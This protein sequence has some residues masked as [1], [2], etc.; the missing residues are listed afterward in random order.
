MYHHSTN[1]RKNE[2]SGSNGEAQELK[3]VEGLEKAA[4]DVVDLLEEMKQ[5]I[6]G[7]KEMKQQVR[8]R[9]NGNI[10]KTRKV[11]ANLRNIVDEK[12]GQTIAD[13]RKG[14]DCTEKALKVSCNQVLIVVSV[15]RKNFVVK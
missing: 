14:A 15:D 13:I 1:H 7:V 2:H 3:E 9:K 6:L 10:D 4:N 12:E 11:F 8:S 5:A